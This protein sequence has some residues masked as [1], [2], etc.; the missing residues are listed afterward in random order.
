VKTARDAVVVIMRESTRLTSVTRR[1]GIFYND[2]T[3]WHGR[4]VP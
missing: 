4:G 2:D 3:Q 1:I